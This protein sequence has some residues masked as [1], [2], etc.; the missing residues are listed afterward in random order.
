[1]QLRI[2]TEHLED[3]AVAWWRSLTPTERAVQLQAVG[4]CE[5]EPRPR[6]AA[7]RRART[8]VLCTL[9]P[10]VLL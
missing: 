2:D 8:T 10:Q 5:D 9:T 4:E 1:M 6:T 7:E 3:G